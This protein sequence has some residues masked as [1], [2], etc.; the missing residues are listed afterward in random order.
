MELFLA[1][2]DDHFSASDDDSIPFSD[3]SYDLEMQPRSQTHYGGNRTPYDRPGRDR[4]PPPMCIICGNRPQYS[5]GSKSYPT[6]GLTC[7]AKLREIQTGPSKT[8]SSN[9]CVV[10]HVRPKYSR[11]GKSYPTCGLTCAAKLNPRSGPVEII[12]INGQ[13]S[14]TDRGP[15]HNVEEPAETRQESLQRPVAA[16]YPRIL[17]GITLYASCA[18]RH[19]KAETRTF[20]AGAKHPEVTLHSSAVFVTSWTSN[21]P[22]P[23]VKKVYKIIQKPI[24]ATDYDKYRSILVANEFRRWHGI[25]RDC[26]VGSGGNV[27]TCSSKTCM[28]CQ[29]LQSTFD[30]ARYPGGAIH[31]SITSDMA[32]KHSRSARQ[33]SSKAML[34]VNVAAGRAMK[35]TR[36]EF[37][38]SGGAPRGY[39]SVEVVG[40]HNG[41]SV[42]EDLIVYTGSA[43]RPSYLVIYG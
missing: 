5:N 6:C 7:A 42:I 8:S 16:A 22:S 30:T 32:D 43:V 41:K 28:L 12:V 36:S 2:S 20:V 26:D 18:G 35:A 1:D 13:N 39:D 21:A 3:T 10:C 31:S 14:L 23:E 29:I 11:G 19:P 38:A 40:S 9:M 17:P 15:T 27:N 33:S 4:A 24:Y 37:R 25:V 34:L